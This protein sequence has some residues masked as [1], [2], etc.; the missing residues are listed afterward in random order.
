MGRRLDVQ[1]EQQNGYDLGEDSRVGTCLIMRER[2]GRCSAQAR[3]EDDRREDGE[4]N[5]DQQDLDGDPLAPV[6]KKQ[7]E[8]G[9]HKGLY[10][11]DHGPILVPTPTRDA[12]TPGLNEQGGV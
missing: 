10:A 1:S 9:V 7:G 11:S 2:C 8:V 3:C 4:G 5:H 6:R 12:S